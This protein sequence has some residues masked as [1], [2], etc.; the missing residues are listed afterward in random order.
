[1]DHPRL[2]QFLERGQYCFER[3]LVVDVGDQERHA[4]VGQTFS[5]FYTGTQLLSEGVVLLEEAV[6]DA[7]AESAEELG[8]V[9]PLVDECKRECLQELKGSAQDVKPP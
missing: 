9:P 8:P 3:D 4:C 6:D 2:R 5:H 1:M 7:F